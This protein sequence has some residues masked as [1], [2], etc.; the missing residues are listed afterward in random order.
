MLALLFAACGDDGGDGAAQ[1]A[2]EAAT[3][4]SGEFGDIPRPPLA[5]EVGPRAD[6]DGVIAQSF[7]VRNTS[8][9]RIFAFY[10][11]RL[12]GWQPEERPKQLGPAPD[13]AWRATWI[14]DDRRLVVTTSDAPTLAAPTGASADPILQVSLSLEPLA[15]ATS[16]PP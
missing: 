2:E 3:F 4:V 5:D 6:I 7:R 8:R 1:P 15:T 11:E 14:R 12:E 10:D 13:A 9:D 16:P